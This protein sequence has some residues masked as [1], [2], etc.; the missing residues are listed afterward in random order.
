MNNN[1]DLVKGQFLTHY[2]QQTVTAILTLDVLYHTM[3]HTPCRFEVNDVHSIQC[4]KDVRVLLSILRRWQEKQSD[5]QTRIWPFSVQSV[6]KR[7]LE[8]G[9]FTTDTRM[10]RVKE[11]T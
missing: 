5:V 9:I 1:L 11:E 3:P 6:Q 7:A 8:F 4:L 2:T 10:L